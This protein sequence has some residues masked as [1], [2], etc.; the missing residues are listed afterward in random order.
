[1]P[2][3]TCSA[4]ASI[5]IALAEVNEVTSTFA[6][7]QCDSASTSAIFSAVGTKVGSICRPSRGATSATTKAD[8]TYDAIVK[9]GHYTVTA[10]GNFCVLGS[11]RCV[12]SKAVNVPPTQSVNFRSPTRE[13]VVSGTI[14]DEFRRGLR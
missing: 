6:K 11:S 13:K 8:G 9:R 5:G 7:P 10:V 3:I 2:A 1:M 14:R 12:K 4:S